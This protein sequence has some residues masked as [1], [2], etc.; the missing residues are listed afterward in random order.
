ML[1]KKDPK[2]KN[3]LYTNFN[4]YHFKDQAFEGTGVLIF[5]TI[6]HKTYVNISPRADEHVLTA[7]LSHFN[8]VSKEPY[9]AI[10]FK[11]I[12]NG[13]IYH[14]N[15]MLAILNKHAV[16]ALDS[17]PNAKEQQ[18][19]IRELTDPKGNKKPKKLIEVSL[20]EMRNFCC[21]VLQVD[22]EDGT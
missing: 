20:E 2:D 9:K 16:V 14:T 8:S 13:P 19:V 1:A 17:I 7:Y 11:A 6:N 5:D 22:G 12:D 15:V 21:N 10:T 3:V 18:N 4:D